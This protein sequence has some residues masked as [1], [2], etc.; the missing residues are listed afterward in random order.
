MAEKKKTEI[1]F[2]VKA[3]GLA[4]LAG[5]GLYLRHHVI[6]E[7]MAEHRYHQSQAMMHQHEHHNPP[8]PPG[9]YKEQ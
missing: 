4:A 2:L 7:M 5:G 8:H 6:P 9:Y 3:A 1:P